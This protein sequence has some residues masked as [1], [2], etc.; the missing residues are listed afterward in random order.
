[1][2]EVTIVTRDINGYRNYHYLV[3]DKVSDY[4]HKNIEKLETEEILVIYSDGHCLYSL[5]GNN[6]V[7]WF[8]VSGFFA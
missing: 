1:M 6:F 2:E 7:S 5:L 4:I 8:E 3:W